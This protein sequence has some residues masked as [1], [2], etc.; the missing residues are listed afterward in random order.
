[1]HVPCLHYIYIYNIY[2]QLY[3]VL[4]IK[5]SRTINAQY[6]ILLHTQFAI[7]TI[8]STHS[9]LEKD[10]LSFNHVA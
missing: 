4:S 5:Q 7:Y 2:T 6:K 1:M 9:V 3:T 8:Q 10:C